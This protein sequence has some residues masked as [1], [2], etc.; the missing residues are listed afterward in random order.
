[1]DDARGNRLQ[2]LRDARRNLTEIL[3]PHGRWIRFTYDPQDRIIRAE[4]D[5]GDWAQ[6]TYNGDGVMSDAVFSDGR[7]RHYQYDGYL[8]TSITD[9]TGRV[10][11]QNSYERG[12]LSGQRFANG[13]TYS[14]HYDWSQNGSWVERATVTLP[15]GSTQQVSTGSAVP[16][17]VRNPR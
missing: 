3:T 12:N 11:L 5:R 17:I 10:L 9:G 7:Q 16:D 4:T 15:N 14:Y 2:L 8:M 1:M 13:D 6:Y